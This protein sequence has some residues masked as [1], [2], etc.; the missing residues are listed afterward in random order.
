MAMGDGVY[1]VV[2]VVVVVGL[3][4]R[5]TQGVEGFGPKLATELPRLAE[6]GLQEMERGAV[7]LQPPLPC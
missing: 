5:K 7:G 2:V 3:C 1:K 4:P 6:M